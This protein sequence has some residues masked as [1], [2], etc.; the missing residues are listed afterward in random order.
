MATIL[1]FLAQAIAS[2]LEASIATTF[3]F[4]NLSLRFKVDRMKHL[5]CVPLLSI[6]LASNN[7]EATICSTFKKI[8]FI[9]YS[10]KRLTLHEHGRHAPVHGTL[11]P[12]RS[13]SAAK[14]TLASS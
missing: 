5:L 6:S 8:L 2:S 3:G 9:I 14:I 1:S 7:A 11:S 10:S 12:I 4:N 13:A